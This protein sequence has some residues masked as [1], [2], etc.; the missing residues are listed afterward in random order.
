MQARELTGRWNTMG[1]H[2]SKQKNKS[3]QLA[4]PTFSQYFPTQVSPHYI[5]LDPIYYAFNTI[6]ADV[7]WLGKKKPKK[8]L[9]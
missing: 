1:S 2:Q 4:G 9:T 3:A 5:Q 8:L 7:V 6:Y